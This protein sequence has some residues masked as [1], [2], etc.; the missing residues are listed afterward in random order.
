[1]IL[2]DSYGWI[3]CFVEGPSTGE[4]AKLVETEDP[5]NTV[6]TDNVLSQP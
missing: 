3:E 4:Y 6:N 5:E 2:I 1:M